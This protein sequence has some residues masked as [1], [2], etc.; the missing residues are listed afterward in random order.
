MEDL[1]SNTPK[2]Q[3]GVGDGVQESGLKT[4]IRLD[5]FLPKLHIRVAFLPDFHHLSLVVL[6]SLGPFSSFQK[7]R[8]I[9]K[10]PDFLDFFKNF[11]NFLNILN[12]LNFSN[13][14]KFSTKCF[15]LRKG[16]LLRILRKI[17][18]SKFLNNSQNQFLRKSSR[19]GGWWGPELK[20]GP[21][22]RYPV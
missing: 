15:W 12:I 5:P 21:T 8:K 22:S 16:A 17:F 1:K 11:R 4:Q 9:L 20:T 14:S 10:Y 19:F 6:I 7:K 18:F 3:G 2:M 13:F